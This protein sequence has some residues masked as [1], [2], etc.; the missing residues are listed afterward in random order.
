MLFLSIRLGI[1]KTLTIITLFIRNVNLFAKIHIF[2]INFL[3]KK[4]L[5]PIQKQAF[6]IIRYIL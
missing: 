2:P 1:Y 5:L 6:L 3:H 4:R